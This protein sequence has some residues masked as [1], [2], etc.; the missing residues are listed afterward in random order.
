MTNLIDSPIGKKCLAIGSSYQS[1][2]ITRSTHKCLAVVALIR[3]HWLPVRPTNVLRPIALIRALR[4]PD[5]LTNVLR[6]VALI[7]A[8]STPDR[9]TFFS[10][11]GSYK[12]SLIP[13]SNH[14]LPNQSKLSPSRWISWSL[15]RSG[16]NYFRRSNT[17]FMWLPPQQTW[18]DVM[19]F[20]SCKCGCFCWIHQSLFLLHEVWAQNAFRCNLSKTSIFEPSSLPISWNFLAIAAWK[21][22]AQT[23]H[24]WISFAFV[25]K[26]RSVLLYSPS[27]QHLSFIFSGIF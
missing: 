11:W 4:H 15:A 8:H 9:P 5:R 25:Y 2:L 7:R 17:V 12:S 14:W 26:A 24:N 16:L 19:T 23:N 6:S 13:Q 22:N 10:I 20:V 21:F 27:E 3:A 18:I 1:S